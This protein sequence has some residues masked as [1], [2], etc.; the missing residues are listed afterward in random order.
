MIKENFLFIAR[1]QQN[2]FGFIGKQL[3]KKI[4]TKADLIK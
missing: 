2:L 4:L 1:I 3:I